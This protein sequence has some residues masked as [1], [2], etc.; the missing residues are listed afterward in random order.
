MRCI[1]V[2]GSFPW[3]PI[4]RMHQILSLFLIA[5]PSLH[6]EDLLFPNS[7]FESG[8]LANWTA[9]GTA[10][11]T[12]QPTFGDNT[13]ARGNVSCNKQGDYWI[14]T[15]ENYDGVNGSPGNV[16]GDGATGTLTSPS[17]TIQKRYITFLIGGGNHPGLTGVK[18]VCEGQDY[19]TA[20]GADTES[21][22]AVTFDA[23]AL[24][25]K[26]ANLVIFDQ[27][28]GGWGHINVDHFQ[29][30]DE[31]APIGF[32]LTPGIPS[33]DAPAVGYDQPLRPQF[34]FTSR[35]NWLNDPNGMVF[36][37]EK[38][39]FFFQHN[40]LGPDWG[41]MTWGHAVSTD[42]IHW[43]QLNHALLPYQVEGR[44]G[45]IFSGSAVVDHNNSLVYQVSSRKTLA[46]FFTYAHSPF[47]QAMAYSTNGGVTWNYH[48]YGR[49]VVPNQGFDAGERDPKVF[50]HEASQ[51]WVML[52]WVQNNPGRVRFF[53]SN[54][55]K[56]WNFA[57][58]LL[59]NWAFECM[60]MFP[61]PVDGNPANTK[62]VVYDA[63]FDY[64][65]GSFD[66]TT[67]TTE[68]GPFHASHGNF[69]AAQT[70]N[71]AP[72][73]RVVQIGWMN[74]GP[75]SASAY[76]LPF[77]QQMSF[78]CELTLKTTPDGVRLCANPVS[79]IASLVSS[80]YQI[81]NQALNATNLL[82]TAGPLDLADL[83]IEFEPGTASQIVIDLPRTTV[84]YNV[85][86][87]TLTF[88]DVNGNASSLVDGVVTQRAGWVKLRLLLDRL[89]LEGY[90]FDG[91][92][93]GSHYLSPANGTATP[94]ITA[95][96][97]EG[98]VH[99]LTVHKLNS[100]WTP[101]TPLS[102][103]LQNPGFEEG[104][105]SGG[106]FSHTVPGWTTFG[107]WSDAA[108][109]W[110]DSCNALTQAAGFPDFT[111]LGAASFKARNAATE[112]RA[113]IYQSLGRVALSDLGKTFT[114]GADLGARITDGPGNHAHSG[115]MTVSFRK[116]LT[117]GVPGDGGVLLGAAGTR[118]ITADDAELPSLASVTPV[119][120]TAVFTPALEDV[121]SE[122]FA[123]ID[124]KNLT[125][126]PDALND[127]KHYIADNVTL[128]AGTPSPPVGLLCYE[129]FD[130]ATG[131]SSLTGK[132]GGYGWTGSWVTVNNGS[133]DVANGSLIAGS[134]A[135]LDAASTG[136]HA[137]L[138]N[139]R[140]VGRFLDTSP[141]GPFGAR[142][143][144]DPAGRI[145]KDGS[146][147]YLSFLQKPNG[148]SL[149]YE[150]EFHRGDLGDPGRIAGIGNDQSGNNVYLR[151]PNNTHSLIGA[152]DTNVN[153]YVVRID[154]KAGNDDVHVYRNPA[155]STEPPSPTLTRLNAADLSFDG[156]S[157]GAFVNGRTVSHDELRFGTTWAQVIAEA[158][159]LT[160]SRA[161]GL[162]ASGGSENGFE[163]DADLDSVPNGL[164]WILGGDPITFDAAS[165]WSGNAE[166]GL[167]VTFDRDPDS[168]G[169]ADLVFQWCQDLD[170]N[171]IDVPIGQNSGTYAG[172]V[173]VSI[174]GNTI[175][176]HV[177][178]HN[179]TLGRL[180]GRL[181]AGMP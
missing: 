157:F 128:S 141:N 54:N 68:A 140:R 46:A 72:N 5:V 161:S 34:H 137:N 82:A 160:W 19:P 114:L 76:G 8:N 21:M 31:P 79:E 133:A 176:V 103:T 118:I 166:D 134:P 64:E 126:S 124:L 122:V 88:T 71:Q 129:G 24:L 179:A 52:L 171:W 136:N 92:K 93:F 150:F 30:S 66:G 74:G 11:T 162:T 170:E 75:N 87:G 115:E 155:S 135:D 14:G 172:G 86:G 61:L 113:G 42:M 15:Y 51:K 138:P 35:R 131:S 112:N 95:V 49:A 50:W 1:P 109:R 3:K 167:T 4:L 101:E 105:P 55:L 147:L 63:S 151:A 178:G 20:S 38:Y 59:R 44:N 94:S 27:A 181:K 89:S 28:T 97:G 156:I 149:F 81:S 77:N 58:D 108:G 143:L 65:I 100:A 145:G 104:I 48:D 39:H 22:A 163:D 12:R 17:F 152:G 164:E 2:V 6:A 168:M 144:V 67:F 78:P 29:A 120:T 96:G 106:I 110:D 32:Q 91:E 69:Y 10:F 90:V 99:S 98:W 13:A 139:G 7:D 154:F 62:W 80:T 175:T 73:G 119:R 60:D 130:Y 177:P 47:Y 45:T 123:V 146:T 16:R 173:V 159:Y 169:H 53:T 107:D 121:G 43:T 102:T 153:F 127:E 148:T 84:R 26:S 116:G 18:L 142:G 70:F 85:S 158:P 165:V 25:G 56:D 57:S 23:Q 180:F 41:N 9:S 132:N 37:G 33:A 174:V 83:S 40:P 117:S 111:G 36:D 125:S